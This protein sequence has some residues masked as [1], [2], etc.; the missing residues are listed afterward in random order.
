MA[1]PG[2]LSFTV[3][4]MRERVAWS[5]KSAPSASVPEWPPPSSWPVA[6]SSWSAAVVVAS[7]VVRRSRAR[8]RARRCS[9]R[10][11]ARRRRRR[12]RPAARADREVAVQHRG[13][14]VALEVVGPRRKRDRPGGR[15]GRV[16]VGRLVHPGP[17]EVEVVERRH[18]GDV[19]RVRPRRERRDGG[20]ALGQR[21]REPGADRRR[22]R[23]V[24]CPRRSAAGGEHRRDDAESEET[25]EDRPAHAETTAR[26]S[27]WIYENRA[28]AA[29]ARS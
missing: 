10:R 19:H 22:Q 12:R 1:C 7:V 20:A 29:A 25:D 2:R 28:T 3:T 27:N 14:R 8:R 15:A 23:P 13:V 5:F 17:A 21:N 6:R 4:K 26:A 24:R 11:R 16:D 9:C 18:I